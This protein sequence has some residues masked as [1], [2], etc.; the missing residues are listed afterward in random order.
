MN[1]Y[2][3]TQLNFLYVFIVVNISWNVSI[4][5]TIYD[6]IETG[7]I[8]GFIFFL[9]IRMFIQTAQLNL[10]YNYLNKIKHI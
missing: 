2:Q 6:P 3:S 1:V 8:A 9:T 4:F 7:L 10:I 5:N